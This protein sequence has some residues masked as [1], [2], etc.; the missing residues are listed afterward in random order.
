MGKAPHGM[1]FAREVE[2][3]NQTENILVYKMPKSLYLR[4]YSDENA[5][6]L[7]GKESCEPWEMFSYMWNSVMPKHR[8]KMVVTENNEQIQLEIFDSADGKHGK[9]WAYSAVERK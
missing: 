9:G 3:E 1:I 2:N 6:K 4:I 8:L 5:A 7:I